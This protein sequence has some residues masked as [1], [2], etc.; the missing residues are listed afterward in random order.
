MKVFKA[1]SSDE[2]LNFM[3]DNMK[4]LPTGQTTIAS[5]PVPRFSSSFPI[6]DIMKD[7]YKYVSMAVTRGIIPHEEMSSLYQE[8]NHMMIV[9]FDGTIN[10]KNCTIEVGDVVF[11]KREEV[12]HPNDNTLWG[13]VPLGYAVHLAN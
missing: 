13:F 1:T 10:T 9:V 2:I 7:D 6:D 5:I 3:L 12:F 11:F 4:T 8:C